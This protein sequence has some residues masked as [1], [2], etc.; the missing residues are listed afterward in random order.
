MELHKIK[1]LPLYQEIEL[2]MKSTNRNFQNEVTI[3]QRN[4]F[5]YLLRYLFIK[6]YTVLLSFSLI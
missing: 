5:V 2:S 1:F 6:V 4:R 3:T